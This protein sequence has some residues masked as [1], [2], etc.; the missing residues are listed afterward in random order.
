M[1]RHHLEQTRS[2]GTGSSPWIAARFDLHYRGRQVG[3]HA[4]RVRPAH[5]MI[6]PVLDLLG[7]DRGDCTGGDGGGRT[8]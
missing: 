8:W 3:V 1:E 5:D 4:G 7:E 6:S 2:A